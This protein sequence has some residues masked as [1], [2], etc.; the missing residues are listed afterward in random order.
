M[1]YQK[2]T[3]IYFSPTGHTAQYAVRLAGLLG[4][5]TADVDLTRRENRDRQLHFSKNDLVILGAP[6]YGGRLPGLPGQPLFSNLQGDNTPAILL[7]TYGNRHYDDALL[8]LADLAREKGFIPV[9]GAALL[10]RHTNSVKIGGDRPDAA[11]WEAF[12]QAAAA[13]KARLE[14]IGA[15]DGLRDSLSVP[16]NRPYRASRKNVFFPQADSRCTRCGKC[17]QVCPTGA[18]SANH[19]EGADLS[20]CINCAACV[21][22]CPE[23]ARAF[24]EDAFWE[25]VHMLEQKCGPVRR[26]A[27]WYLV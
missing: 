15:A 21:H 16:G 17:V 20:L 18:I 5:N 10:A 14:G 9:A 2:V 24:R 23:G 12:A 3:A 11:D 7:V 27:E 13:L 25:K 6:V 1:D 19:L 8:E 22:Q 4:G 26:E